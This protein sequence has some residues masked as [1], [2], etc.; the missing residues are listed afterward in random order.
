MLI[1][2]VPSRKPWERV[3]WKDATLKRSGW[4]CHYAT[5]G[6][7]LRSVPS[8][9]WG[10]TANCWIAVED[11]PDEEVP[12]QALAVV[13]AMQKVLT[14]GSVAPM[15]PQA[16][17]LLLLATSTDTAVLSSEDFA[18]PHPKHPSLDLELVESSA[19]RAFA[20]CL[21]KDYPH[22][23]AWML[24]QPNFDM[25][26]AA[27][28][29]SENQRSTKEQNRRCD[30]LIH[31]ASHPVIAEI[32]GLQHSSAELS[33][34]ARDRALNR[35]G[36]P[37][38]RIPAT[39]A[40][41]S[42]GDPD[43]ELTRLFHDICNPN[44]QH[45]ELVWGAAQTHRLAAALCEGVSHGFL[46][47]DVWSIKL[48]DQSQTA[49]HCIGPY[50]EMLDGFDLMWSDGTVAPQRVV[51]DAGEH[52]HIEWY[53][54]S[55]CNYEKR[56]VLLADTPATLRIDLQL[57]IGPFG[58]LPKPESVPAVI[59]RSAPLQWPVADTCGF[60]SVLP[61]FSTCT[62]TQR[63]VALRCL[64]L[65]IF[66]LDGFHEGQI[67]AITELL[68][69]RDSVVLLPTGAGKSLIYQMAGLC[70]PGRSL[71]VDPLVSL[72][73]DQVESLAR[74]GID[75]A[76]GISMGNDDLSQAEHSYFVFVTPQRLQRQRFRDHL[77]RLAEVMPVNL[78]VVDEAHCV[79]EWGHDFMPAYLNFG[80]TLRTHCQGG[81][82][83]PPLL[84]LTGTASQTVLVDMMFQ[85]GIENQ[86][87]NSIVR[88]LSFDRKELTFHVQRTQPKA[89][90]GTLSQELQS[91]PGCFAE[92]PQTFFTALGD[93]TYSGIVF[94]ST[95]DGDRGLSPAKPEVERVTGHP[96]SIYASTAPKNIP[97]GNWNQKKR[98]FAKDFMENKTSVMLSTKS[99][100]MGID[101]QN[102]RWVMHYGLPSSI[103]GYYQEA[104]RAGRDGKPAHCSLVLIEQD[105]DRNN[106]RLIDSDGET[107]S[108]SISWEEQDDID[109]ALYFHRIAFPDPQQEHKNV[110]T[111][112][113][114]IAG[115]NLRFPAEDP[116][117]GL[118]QG[119]TERALHR[120]AIL[121]VV[122]DYVLVGSNSTTEVIVTRGALLQPAEIVNNAVDYMQRL[123][124]S[125][126]K[127]ARS[128]LST[129][130]TSVA[131]A[132]SDCSR[133]LIDFIYA[134][135]QKARKRSLR[136][137]WLMA[138]D[139]ADRQDGEIIRQR[140]LEYLNEGQIAPVVLKLA[141][142]PI[143]TFK[144]WITQWGKIASVADAREWRSAAARLLASYPEHPGLL[145]SR[146]LAEALIPEGN[147]EEVTT[148]LLHAFRQAS[149]T[150]NCGPTD[151]A[152][153]TEWLLDSLVA[154][155]D[156][157][158]NKSLTLH[159]P[160]YRL[161]GAIA[162]ASLAH[163]SSKEA[164]E[165][166]IKNRWKDSKALAV[167]HAINQVMSVP[168]TLETTYLQA[169]DS[170]G[171]SMELSPDEIARFD[172][173][174][175]A[176]SLLKEE[177]TALTSAISP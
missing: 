42:T 71:V 23:A 16:E 38:C 149:Q 55:H 89:A 78:A 130:H 61:A 43:T 158:L 53:R 122:Q 114:K 39:Q 163:S 160:V 7:S 152:R 128:R 117:H 142:S 56:S 177:S 168:A 140:I 102:I 60:P 70:M 98:Q 174:F 176:V 113:N 92:E 12:P 4:Q 101:K 147:V 33:D 143:F 126:A 154:H 63:E 34:T 6:A 96:V 82:G 35:A 58:T 162:E 26:Q 29:I 45:R 99:F 110:L 86:T 72:I 75:R 31:V 104:G 32:D 3:N 103:E 88:P 65:A 137:M 28:G 40:A 87:T 1:A 161:I 145:L 175:A 54:E 170:D 112:H 139:A 2:T 120:L 165:G 79:S 93:D 164:S 47:G 76:V 37:V 118:K 173:L 124:P 49:V 97:S 159:V 132:V 50:L 111:V 52:G 151:M 129:G 100:G 19:E 106:D 25:M 135:I 51:F 10:R 22:I 24:P 131:H 81:L 141:E 73:D 36:I 69:Q 123:Q 95:I 138:S 84:A 41:S 13:S 68:H 144:K 133:T 77:Q 167:R 90:W 125:Q 157:I 85:L 105:K 15:H 27:G 62:N 172:D 67:E 18:L 8:E 134:T 48:A 116:K 64:L 148:D 108:D 109:T 44:G 9:L 115:G 155:P 127:L 119:S 156:N 94:V 150:Y 169:S 166:W 80:R 14:R 5:I 136:E 171:A 21:R 121:G 66:E 30:F 46:T 74:H 107:E 91:M 83:I 57:T 59:V 17:K 11:K 146:G 20:G 153:I